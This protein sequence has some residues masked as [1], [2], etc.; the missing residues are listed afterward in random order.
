MGLNLRS[1]S[2]AIGHLSKEI[3]YR[4]WWALFMLD[5]VLCVMTGRPP[6]TSQTFCS[7]PLPLPYTEEEFGDEHIM[8]LI[9]DQQARNTFM[10]SL[11]SSDP[12]FTARED[13]A[14][15]IRFGQPESEEKQVEHAAQ[16]LAP[17]ISLYFLY[18]VDLAFL[19]REAVDTLYAPRATRR[20]WSRLGSS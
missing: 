19:T 2:T 1:E 18:A 11:L 14:N 7:T 13:L 20:T 4:V 10:T 5:T 6:S 17:N 9:T 3:R 8:R 16:G 12:G 15:R